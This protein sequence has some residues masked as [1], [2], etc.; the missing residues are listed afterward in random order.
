MKLFHSF[1]LAAAF[2]AAATLPSNL[3]AS[4]F[5][6]IDFSVNPQTYME[7]DMTGTIWTYG[8]TGAIGKSN[9]A[10]VNLTITTFNGTYTVTQPSDVIDFNAYAANGNLSLTGGGIEDLWLTTDGGNGVLLE[11]FY[12]P[13]ANQ[14]S[15]Y[16]QNIPS[17][18]YY[19]YAA[20]AL[21]P[22]SLDSSVAPTVLPTSP[23]PQ[24]PALA[25]EPASLSM[26][27]MAGVGLIGFTR[28][29]RARR[30]RKSSLSAA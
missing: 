16:V 20:S 22:I 12:N 1:T 24:T 8:A 28:I 5:Y 14:D 29:L 3:M 19:Y 13:Q 27:G 6:T 21:A 4:Q 2:I 17:G 30:N 15:I 23:S 11:L 10:Q 26:M 25:P 18:T 9:L 7:F